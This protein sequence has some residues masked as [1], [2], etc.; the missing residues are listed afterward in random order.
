MKHWDKC[1]F[2]YRESRESVVGIATGYG[3]DDQRVGDRVLVGARI[4][5]APCRADGS[6]V[7]PT[8]YPMVA[9]GSFPAGKLAGA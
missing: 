4:F 2:I 7:H 1:F 3:L 9:G 6:G 8:S 5:P